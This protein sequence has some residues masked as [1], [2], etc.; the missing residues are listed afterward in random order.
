MWIAAASIESFME[1]THAPAEDSIEAGAKMACDIACAILY[2]FNNRKP[3][4]R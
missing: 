3:L 2:S 4:R 1:N